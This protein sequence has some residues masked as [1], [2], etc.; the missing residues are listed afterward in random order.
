MPL[1]I[2]LFLVA[3]TIGSA[4]IAA[5]LFKD[6]QTAPGIVAIVATLYFGARLAGLGQ[7]HT[8]V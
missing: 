7:K 4:I 2:R 6:R 8:E 5:L 1:P 3:A